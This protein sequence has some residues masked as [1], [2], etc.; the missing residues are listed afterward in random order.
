M[1]KEIHGLLSVRGGQYYI[2]TVSQS[3]CLR[4]IFT[5]FMEERPAVK[6]GDYCEVSVRIKRREQN[7][8]R[9][10]IA[11]VFVNN[12]EHHKH[13]HAYTSVL[14]KPLH[15]LLTKACNYLNGRIVL[16]VTDEKSNSIKLYTDDDSVDS[17]RCEKAHE[18]CAIS[19]S[20]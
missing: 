3:V 17:D 15:E 4:S 9:I 11:F 20:K 7:T 12:S 14:S 16:V 19:M 13:S 8:R 5:C 1:A 2:T 18:L 10:M 6:G